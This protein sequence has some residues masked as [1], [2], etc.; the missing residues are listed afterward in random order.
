MAN[1]ILLTSDARIFVAQN[2]I[3]C[4]REYT[5]HACMKMGSVAKNYGE[6]NPIYC[7]GDIPGEFIQVDSYRGDETPWT[8][9]LSG[10][11]PMGQRS[12][13]QRLAKRRG[14]LDLQ[15]HFG[16]C[17]D[18]SDFS[19][20]E[21]AIIFEDVTLS[22]YAIDALGA[23]N[24]S[25]TAPI[26]ESVNLSAA[27]AYDIH[28]VKPMAVASAITENAVIIDVTA[29]DDACDQTCF[30][31]C[32]TFYAFRFAV[33]LDDVDADNN[34]II[35]MRSTDGGITWEDFA[36]DV[37]TSFTALSS[38]LH[39]FHILC[40]R[41]ALFIVG[42]EADIT[43]PGDNGGAV[44]RI[45]LEDI[46]TG[47]DITKYRRAG[48]GQRFSDADIH[49]GVLYLVGSTGGVYSV[50]GNSLLP[51][52]IT[53]EPPSETPLD[54][55]DVLDENNFLVA[56]QAFELRAHRNGI[57][58]SISCVTISGIAG[59]DIGA[60]SMKSATEWLVA[61]CDGRMY[62]TAD[63]GNTWNLVVGGNAAIVSIKFATKHV[64]YYLTRSPAQIYRTI[65]GGNSWTPVRDA[66]NQVDELTDYWHSLV[67]CSRDP[68]VFIATGRI[69]V[70]IEE[71]CNS[72]DETCQ[73]T[74][75]TVHFGDLG[76]LVSGQVC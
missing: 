60:I 9:S 17:A 73:H 64:G 11:K 31:G 7:P 53:P 23:L 44:Y 32:S 75:E 28:C 58:T 30:A 48:F 24:A 10:Y 13:L 50:D 46:V 54:Y 20:Y 65:D 39:S 33:P 38:P 59:C 3:G 66:A 21:S 69:P 25:E 19:A 68:N 18:L 51:T 29:C 27:H 62:C 45:A 2:G 56:S 70:G 36:F 41:D 72:P 1:E 71:A 4:G 61:T 52:I 42:D 40:S 22:G 57:V 35:I 74:C 8:T 14:T 16:R 49:N 55:I 76:L 12:L 34:S 5:Y 43:D 15:V 26:L 63:S 6:S 67:V 47:L 37:T